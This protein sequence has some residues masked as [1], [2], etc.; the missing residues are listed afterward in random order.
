MRGVELTLT[1]RVPNGLSGWIGYAYADSHYTHRITGETWPSD[2][3]QRH[4]VTT[5]GSYRLNDRTSVSGR[6]RVAT[7]VPLVGYYQRI[8]DLVALG[9]E[10]SSRREL[11]TP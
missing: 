9:D 3:E 4:S 7:N 6:F 1:R 5:Y 2:V 11:S 10:R 8:G